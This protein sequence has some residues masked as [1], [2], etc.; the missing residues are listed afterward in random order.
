MVIFAT[1][2]NKSVKKIDRFILVECNIVIVVL[3]YDVS[4]VVWLFCMV[5]TM[6]KW[7]VYIFFE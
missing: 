3:Y 5:Q 6:T 1:F 2:T 4:F 7:M